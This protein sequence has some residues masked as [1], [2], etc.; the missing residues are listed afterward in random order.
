MKRIIIIS[1]GQTEQSFCNDVLQPHLNERGIYIENPAIKKTGGGIVRWDAL[2]YQIEAHLLQDKTAF[3]TTLVDFYGLY[4]NMD[5]PGWEHSLKLNDKSHRLA[6]L[7]KSMQEDIRPDL[8]RR[9]MPYIQLHE[10]EGLLFCEADVFDRNFE[11]NE[12]LN[13]DYL[14]ETIEQNPNPEMINDGYETAPSKRLEKI[15]KRYKSEQKVIY[16]TLLAQEIGLNKI[17]SKCPRF[18]EWVDKLERLS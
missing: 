13:Y 16:G 1:E 5:F 14:I 3:V 8:Q 15:I 2:K 10:F 9:F 6:F 17:R 4:A 7:E 11:K 18:N 12:F